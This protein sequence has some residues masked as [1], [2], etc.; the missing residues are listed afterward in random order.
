M[1]NNYDK[2]DKMKM[3]VSKVMREYKAGKLKSSSGDRSSRVIRRLPSHCPRPVWPRK[4]SDERGM[5]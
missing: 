3:K 2:E 5:G 4:A 1:P